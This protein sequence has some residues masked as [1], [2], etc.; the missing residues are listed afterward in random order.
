MSDIYL[1]RCREL[2]SI[3][4]D[5]G[6]LAGPVEVEATRTDVLCLDVLRMTE[7]AHAVAAEVLR[8]CQYP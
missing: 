1:K 3:L 4:R 8:E 7:A 2:A 5:L 6:A